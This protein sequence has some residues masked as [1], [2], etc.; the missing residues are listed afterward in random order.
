MDTQINIPVQPG[1]PRY[2]PGFP[3]YIGAAI[4]SSPVIID[5]NQ[6]GVSDIIFGAQD[7]TVYAY[8]YN[9]NDS[10]ENPISGWPKLTDGAVFASPAVGDIFG[11][12][13]NY[14]V[15]ATMN[16]SIYIWDNAGH[17]LNGWP[18]TLNGNPAIEASPVLADVDHDGRLDVIVAARQTRSVYCFDVLTGLKWFNSAIGEINSTPAVANIMKDT[19]GYLQTVYASLDGIL[20]VVDHT[21]QLLWQAAAGGS[22]FSSPAIADIDGDGNMEVVIGCNDANLYSWRYNTL[23]S[24]W[25]TI[26]PVSVT[27]SIIGSPAIADLQNNDTLSIVFGTNAAK[28]YS[29][30]WDSGL[31]NLKKQW[32][33]NLGDAVSNSPAIGDIN[34]DILRETVIGA[35]DGLLYWYQD[36]GVK[37]AAW[38]D[39]NPLSLLGTRIDSSPAIGDVMGDH[40]CCI[41]VGDNSGYLYAISMASPA[42]PAPYKSETME[43]PMFHHDA[44]HTGL[45][46]TPTPTYLN[47][48]GTFTEPDDTTHWYF[49]AYGDADPS[50]GP[51]TLTWAS[52]F[53]SQ[54]GVI[55]LLQDIGQKGKLTQ[56]FSIP[57][58]GW[59]T[60]QAKIATDVANATNQ[61]KVYLYLQELASDS[62]IAATG[63]VVIAF[64]KGG[65]GSASTWRDIKV[66]FYATNTILGVQIVGIN[67]QANG[68]DNARLYIDD[69][70]VYDGVSQSTGI[71]ALTNPNF[72]TDTSGW[73]LENYA[74]AIGPGIWYWLSYLPGHSG[75][76]QGTQVA[77]EKGKMSQF[78][79]VPYAEHDAIGSVWVYSDAISL[80]D[81]QKVYLYLYSY[82]SGYNNIVESGNAILQPG[83]WTPG[84]WRQ[85]QFGYTPWS[86]FNAV[87]LVGINPLGRPTQSIY[88]DEVLIKQD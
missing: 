58:S 12:E 41:V 35:Q 68:I 42:F 31:N 21:G 37:P 43:W 18:I 80:S 3:I 52:S 62:S 36:I 11:N 71:V 66:S 72:D 78:A 55:A 9:W 81:T 53:A 19:T 59:Y 88:F 10:E 15:A 49:Q 29:Y 73:V 50:P 17:I 2:V 40:N 30:A 34:G 8:E 75:V 14:V 79:N 76:L 39:F 32:E 86:A 25:E 5:L 22:F 38:G 20:S 7:S 61:Q 83:K 85:L 65:L 57:S 69:V 70:I 54:N 67:H 1:R 87:Q 47:N 33:A 64:G 4:K 82:D 74:D 77:G 51:G 16:G 84:V 63:N 44:Q 56:V 23:T 27:G 60:A 24:S 46:S 26:P 13:Q 28:V 6:N 48:H 45:Y